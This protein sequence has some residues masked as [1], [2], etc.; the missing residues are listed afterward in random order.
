MELSGAPSALGLALLLAGCCL[1]GVLWLLAGARHG[2]GRL[3]P[4]PPPLP[5]LGNLLQ[6]DP[7]AMH[8]SLEKL[9]QRYGP[10]YTI[11]LSSLPCVVLC[12][13]QAVKEALVDQADD[14]SDRGDFPVFY[15]F[16]QGNGIAFSNGEKWKVLRRFALQT[17]KNFGMGKSS[18]E[19]RIQKEAQCLVQEFRKTGGAP[20]NP[21]NLVCRAVSNV[22]CAVVFGNRFDYQDSAFLTLLDHFNEN[23]KIMSSFWGELY[24]I[25]PRLMDLLPGPHQQIFRNFEKLKQ[26]IA[27]RIHRHQETLDP[28]APRDFIDC[29]LIRMEQEKQD[30]LSYFHMETLV[31][32][33]HNL[34]FGGTETTSTTL[35]YSFLILMKY[36]EVA[37]QVY[38]EMDQVIG[39]ERPPCLADRKLMPYTD[40]VIYEI[41]R[42]ISIL[43]MG[44]PRAVT[45]DTPFRDFL[46]PKGTNVIPLLSS[47]HYDPS[48]FKDPNSFN[49]A[50]F[51]DERKAFRSKEAFMPFAPGK[52]ICLGA[53]LARMEI[54]L[55][56]TTLLQHFT[57]QPLVPPAEI[58][59]APQCTG[60]GNIPPAFQFQ[61]LPR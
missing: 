59:L 38:Q 13:Y 41:Q 60:L 27:E 20:F 22:I 28:T 2:R 1:S 43:P 54:F 52:R 53:G 40:A 12:G 49:P 4:G 42:F 45:R 9:S 11:H 32:T 33:T 50:N 16:T 15:R 6:L 23:F 37:A 10:V 56:L 25:F 35:R 19:E 7:R 24:N 39:S 34:F 51:L 14:F 46:L 57:L 44:L 18:I 58:D 31:M 61:V 48:Q 26:F 30:P 21:I 47:V 17:L 55:F 3:P 8:R 36:P 5:L 29:F